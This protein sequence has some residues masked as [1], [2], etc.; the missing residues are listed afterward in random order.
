MRLQTGHIVAAAVLA[1]VFFL[2]SHDP[3][4]HTDVWAHMRFGEYIVREH[5][6]PDHEMF[7]GDFADQEQPYLNFQW[8]PQTVTYLVY[9]LGARLAGGDYE[10]QLAGGALALATEHA[11]LV[12]LR[13]LVM[14]FIFHRLTG[15]VN[16]ALFGVVVV[17]ALSLAH[18]S[19][20]RPQAFGELWFAL[21]FLAL[22][23]KK[24]SASVSWSAVVFIPLVLV[25]WA[26]CH[27]SFPMG[28]AVLGAFVV[29]ELFSIF[30]FRFLMGKDQPKDWP[31][32][33]NRKS[34]IENRKRLFLAL[35]LSLAAVTVL[36]PHGPRLFLYSI[37][38]SGN[39][40]IKYIEEWK[41]L[42]VKS[43]AAC[44]F[45]ASCLLL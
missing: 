29:G 28:F 7:S 6:L 31:E 19:V 26:N 9:E 3:V 32:I 42:P 15:S 23:P 14:L 44:L 16:W 18:I 40:N 34:K 36:N 37:Q 30:D 41:P 25:L 1:F 4:W 2:I 43:M 12:T 39:D 45:L 13:L 33:E 11:L 10:R 17:V 21:L 22:T 5:K 38:M 24:G 8:L 27:G 20:H 35:C